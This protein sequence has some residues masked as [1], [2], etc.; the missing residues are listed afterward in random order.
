MWT[1]TKKR[2]PYPLFPK[3][4]IPETPQALQRGG[5]L[6]FGPTKKIESQAEKPD[7]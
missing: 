6:F 7:A 3:P 5:S 2:T 1:S 4:P